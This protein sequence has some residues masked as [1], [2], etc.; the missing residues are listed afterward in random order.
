MDA[1]AYHEAGH[2]VAFSCFGVKIETCE[3]NPV[4][5]DA[6]GRTVP[7][8]GAVL[9]IGRQRLVIAWAGPLAEMRVDPYATVPAS[10]QSSMKATLHDF[11]GSYLDMI[12]E[13]HAAAREAYELVER[14]WKRI[15]KVT[16]ALHE[17]RRLSGDEI[18]GFVPNSG[19]IF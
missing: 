13:L 7:M 3:I 16:D 11:S 17:K 5:G 2:V 10:D 9:P 19:V 14:E 18:E 1:L 6:H 4:P 8:S 12:D 15:K